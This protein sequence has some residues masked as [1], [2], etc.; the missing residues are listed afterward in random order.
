MQKAQAWIDMVNQHKHGGGV[1][2]H[3]QE[4]MW[5]SSTSMEMGS[6]S[7]SKKIYGKSAQAWRKS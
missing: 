1:K 4:E 2:K 5:S 7:T 6:K 3:M